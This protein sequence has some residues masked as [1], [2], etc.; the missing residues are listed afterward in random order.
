MHH[1]SASNSEVRSERTEPR[2]YTA[3]LPESRVIVH[4]LVKAAGL[5]SNMDVGVSFA[6]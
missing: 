5:S 6:E 1:A 2:G 4:H 3:P